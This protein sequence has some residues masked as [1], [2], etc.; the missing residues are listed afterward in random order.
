MP[1]PDSPYPTEVPCTKAEI[2]ETLHNWIILMQMKPGEKISDTEL[3]DYFHVSRTPVREVLK[4]LEQQ[5]LILTYPGKATVVADLDLDK[6]ESYYLPMQTL[7]CLAVRL[8]VDLATN[9]DIDELEHRNLIFRRMAADNNTESLLMAD[10]AF[11]E[12][13]LAIAGNA[14]IQEFCSALW[15]PIARLD[16]LFF[17]DNHMASSAQDHRTI[18]DSFRI[19]DPFGAELA[20]KNNWNYSMLAVEASASAYEYER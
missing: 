4:I 10:H 7:Q 3:A 9:E 11:H 1:L 14:Y 17:R 20:M 6:I 13:I 16:Y 12:K 8:A 5:K 2:L 18:I 15:V 19:R